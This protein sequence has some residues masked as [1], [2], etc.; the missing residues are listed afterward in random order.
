[1]NSESVRG[2]FEYN[3]WR[4]QKILTRAAQIQ[5]WQFDAPTTFPFV[6]LHGTL[7]HLLGVEWLWYQ[8]LHQGVSDRK[9]VV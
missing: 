3:Y 1:M 2:L 6:S 4:N 5:P 7:V 9:S 8:R